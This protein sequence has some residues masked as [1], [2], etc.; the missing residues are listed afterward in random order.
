M[1]TVLLTATI[2]GFLITAAGLV[3]AYRGAVRQVGVSE[4]RLSEAKRL[5]SEW[6][7]EARALGKRADAAKS[8]EVNARY[9]AMFDAREMLPPNYENAPFQAGFEA[10]HALQQAVKGARV[11]LLW[12]AFGLTLSTVASA[13]SLYI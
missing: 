3:Q 5:Y 10:R 2:V 13:W 12:A 6:Q 1:R 4:E 8:A 9:A 11:D 7:A